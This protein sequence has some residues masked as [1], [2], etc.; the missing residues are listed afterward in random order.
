M[1]RYNK[2]EAYEEA[3][4]EGL[5]CVCRKHGDPIYYDKSIGC[6][7]P[8]HKTCVDRHSTVNKGMLLQSVINDINEG[9]TVEDRLNDLRSQLRRLRSQR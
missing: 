8:S 1:N 9:F 5:C 7:H 2:N 3:V 4:R 6:P